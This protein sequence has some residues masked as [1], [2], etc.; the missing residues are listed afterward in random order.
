MLHGTAFTM[1]KND[2]L[3]KDGTITVKY[4]PRIKVSDI[5]WGDNYS[6]RTK[7]ISR[8]FKEDYELLRTAAETPAYFRQQLIYQYIYKGPVLEWYMRIKTKM[9]NNYELFHQLLPEKGHILDIGCGYGFLSYMLQFMSPNRQIM[10]I[11]YDEDKISTAQHNYVKSER[12]NFA[13]ADITNYTFDN[14]DAFVISDV[15]HYLPSDDQ[16]KVLAECI[17]H[18]NP[19]GVII[20]RDGDLNLEKRH[21]RTRLTEFFSTKLIGFNKTKNELSFFSSTR[22]R[23]I[24][25]RYGATMEQIDNTKYTSNVIFIIKKAP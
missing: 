9:E 15:L 6:S 18:L 4:L 20:V 3:L 21:E 16:E 2:F 8:Y 19:G 25:T 10:G 23:E 17:S 12:L 24:V 1:E 5:T 22:M 14:Y 7:Q 11:D 13:Y